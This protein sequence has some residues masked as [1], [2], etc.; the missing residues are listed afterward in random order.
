MITLI[1]NGR[2]ILK[3]Y[4]WLFFFFE[5]PEITAFQVS[6]FTETLTVEMFPIEKNVFAL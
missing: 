1:E 4:P 5:R 3:K 2:G 6:R